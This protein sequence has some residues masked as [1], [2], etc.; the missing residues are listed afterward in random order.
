MLA[1]VNAGVVGVLAAAFCNPV[2]IASVHSPI[3][4]LIG[5]GGWVLLAR[6]GLAP[7][8]V[9]AACIGASVAWTICCVS[10]AAA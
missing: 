4:A 3:D 8:I 10:P 6:A 1:G 5:L 7:L 2:W 9:V